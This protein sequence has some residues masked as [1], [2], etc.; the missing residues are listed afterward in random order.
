MSTDPADRQSPDR[1]QQ[2]INEFL[3]LLPLTT[4]VAGLPL[5]EHGKYFNDAQ[6]ELRVNALRSAYKFA[7]QLILEIAK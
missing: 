4:A 5:S 7:R 3:R 2:K 6:L 1:Q